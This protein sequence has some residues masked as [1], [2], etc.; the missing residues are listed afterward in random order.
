VP[1]LFLLVAAAFSG[2]VNMDLQHGTN[3]VAKQY[4][5]VVLILAF[6]L[7]MIAAAEVTTQN[8]TPSPSPSPSAA[9]PQTIVVP[10]GTT[11]V[12]ALT[13]PI[14]SATAKEN[15]QVA[16]VVKKEVDVS[17]WL[18]IPTGANGHAT[19]TSVEHAAGNG[20]GGKLAMSIDWVY[21]TD[22]EKIQLSE[23][24]HAAE[25]GDTKGAA[26]TATLL[27]WIF[28]GPLGFF[29]HNFV[30]GKDVTIGT[31]KTFTVFVDHDVHVQ[32]SQRAALGEGFAH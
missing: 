22:G 19:V 10:G 18:V 25:T 27:S 13:E 21:D 3:A 8:N 7:P 17:G 28:L 11:V 16:I 26:S 23:T 6:C 2:D 24:N 15:D 20:S 1:G 31:D 4:C 12:V 29:A 9:I 14:S 32:V 5:A 30:R